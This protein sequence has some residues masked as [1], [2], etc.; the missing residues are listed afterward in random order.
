MHVLLACLLAQLIVLFMAWLGRLSAQL[1]QA[2]PAFLFRA[3]IMVICLQ[4]LKH[5]NRQ[6]GTKSE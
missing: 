2:H 6:D 1:L 3:A 4:A 5:A